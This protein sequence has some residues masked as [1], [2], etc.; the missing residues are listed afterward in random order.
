MK[1]LGL[2][3]RHGLGFRNHGLGFRDHM[4]RPAVGVVYFGRLLYPVGELHTSAPI[5]GEVA[6][7]PSPTNRTENYRVYGVVLA[8]NIKLQ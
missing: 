3:F 8:G 5:L 6:A 1:S 7:C 2:G 4:I